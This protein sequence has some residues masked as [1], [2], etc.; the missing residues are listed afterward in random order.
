MKLRRS[1]LLSKRCGNTWRKEICMTKGN[2][3]II[4]QRIKTKLSTPFNKLHSHSIKILQFQ[5]SFKTG[6]NDVVGDFRWKLL[7]YRLANRWT[8]DLWIF[9][10][11]PHFELYS[12]NKE[13]WRRHIQNVSKLLRLIG[14]VY[15]FKT[16]KFVRSWQINLCTSQEQTATTN[17]KPNTGKRSERIVLQNAH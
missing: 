10:Y 3:F 1:P 2:T 14:N 9:Y 17:L 12:K 7:N 11:R 13:F 16:N 4:T 6:I 8:L 5:N 15:Y